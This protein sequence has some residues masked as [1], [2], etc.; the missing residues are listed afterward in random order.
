MVPD[1]CAGRKGN[2]HVEGLGDIGLLLH[3]LHNLLNKSL[4]ELDCSNTG[5]ADRLLLLLLLLLL[6]RALIHSRLCARL[7]FCCC[8]CCCRRLA[9][10]G[11]DLLDLLRRQLIDLKVAD[12]EESKHT[13]TTAFDAEEDV[14]TSWIL[15]GIFQSS[16]KC[17]LQS[18]FECC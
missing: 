1:Q 14:D 7:S 4:G 11:E 15:C 18:D 3:T 9:I 16:T 13:A 17:L 5:R 10:F 6:L 8:C 12:T 2:I